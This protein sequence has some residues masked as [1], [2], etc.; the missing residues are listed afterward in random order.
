MR[1]KRA[2][3][4]DAE[5]LDLLLQLSATLQDL[6]LK[7]EATGV[8]LRLKDGTWVFRDGEQ[9]QLGESLRGLLAEHW[10]RAGVLDGVEGWATGQLGQRRIWTL[11]EWAALALD[12]VEEGPSRMGA[13]PMTVDE[14][15]AIARSWGGKA[16]AIKVRAALDRKRRSTLTKRV[17]AVA[18]ELAAGT[19]QARRW[20]TGQ[21]ERGKP[22]DGEP[23]G[24]MLDAVTAVLVEAGLTH[25]LTDIRRPR[26]V[27]AV[28]PG[29]GDG[30]PKT[31]RGPQQKGRRK[32][33]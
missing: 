5:R 25:R 26:N 1:V 23:R 3:R 21:S 2:K 32:T 29:S 31:A 13:G 24:P 20:K 30:K 28:P 22:Y 9:A 4:S 6:V 10:A 11:E 7:L 27:G 18:Y 8:G 14:A 16:E 17:A 33:P 15:V 19:D 12:V